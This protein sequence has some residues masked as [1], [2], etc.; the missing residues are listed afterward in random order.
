MLQ[1]ICILGLLI[2]AGIISNSISLYQVVKRQP[3]EERVT[4]EP[5]FP[6]IGYGVLMLVSFGIV[7]Y[8]TF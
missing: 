1:L 5:I 8:S 3:V 2:S 7:F 4:T 6:W